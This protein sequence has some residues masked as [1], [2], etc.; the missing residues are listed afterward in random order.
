MRDASCRRSVSLTEDGRDVAPSVDPGA[1]GLWT[2]DDEP[3]QHTIDEVVIASSKT[4]LVGQ[5]RARAGFGM[6]MRVERP[7]LMT[8][9]FS[10][11]KKS[12]SPPRTRSAATGSPRPA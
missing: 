5:L 1:A 4:L 6:V 11:M 2:A 10:T 8:R 3:D 7:M 12:N 9:S